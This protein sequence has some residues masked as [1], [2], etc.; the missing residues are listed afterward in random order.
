MQP[1]GWGN[2]GTRATL[3]TKGIHSLI[4]KVRATWTF[5]RGMR[6][7][8]GEEKV[9]EGACRPGE[10]VEG[11]RKLEAG[12]QASEKALWGGMPGDFSSQ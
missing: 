6:D 10:D 5:L 12:D 11:G 7:C 2:P 9:A 4:I 1:L 8:T 3:V